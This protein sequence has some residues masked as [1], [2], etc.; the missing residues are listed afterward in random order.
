VGGY[1]FLMIAL[2]AVAAAP[3]AGAIALLG[4]NP[5]RAGVNRSL[6]T[7]ERNYTTVLDAERDRSFSE[8]ISEPL[9]RRLGSLGRALTPA[10]AVARLERQLDHAGN[11][12]GWPV[13]RV[14][15]VKGVAAIAGL[16]G[17]CLFGLML[18]GLRAV[19][20]GGV[21]GA[22]VGFF[23]PDMAVHNTGAKR[24]AEIR[25]SLPDVLDTLTVSVEAGQGFDAALAQV[26]R[27]G[28]GP[29]VGEA[30][31]VLQEMR[32]GK[33]RVEALR[34]MSARTTVEELRGFASAVIQ[35]SELGVPIGNVLRE[36]SREMRV[37]R[38]QRAEEQAQKV[39]IK[40]LFPTLFCVFPAL[41]VV[42]L[43]PGVISVMHAFSGR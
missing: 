23:G 43:G 10:G 22:L 33:S 31:R 24:Q 25:S 37:R 17:G 5:E 29:I 3:V 32:I 1:V 40:I 7:I 35:A 9:A 20:L 4:E 19:V 15:G 26:A 30:A 13:E 6:A 18:G 42:V 28:R 11:P 41:F 21:G 16:L 34:G 39:P 38:R 12:P 2:V 36:Q 14:V 27:N 8:R